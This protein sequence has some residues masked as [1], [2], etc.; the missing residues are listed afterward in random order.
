MDPGCVPLE[1]QG[2][3]Q[4]EEMLIS[5]VMPMMSLYRLPME[6]CGYSGHVVNSPQNISSF[7]TS[8]PRLACNIDVILVRKEGA[9]GYHKDFRVRHSKIV[10]A[11]YW[12]KQNNRYYMDI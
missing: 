11:L 2:L 3:T 12:L 9:S 6:Q 8:L 4:V 5:A 1:L 10:S 7:V